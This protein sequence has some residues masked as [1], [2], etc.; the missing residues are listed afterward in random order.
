MKRTKS[1]SI[2]KNILLNSSKSIT[3]LEIF[4]IAKKDGVT[5]STIH[6]TRGP[7]EEENLIK[8]DV[9][10]FTSK[11]SYSW[12]EEEHGH[13]L[14]C[15]KCHKQIILDYCPFEEVNKEVEKKTGFT[16]EDENHVLYGLCSTCKEKNE[17]QK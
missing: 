6:R 7:F 1:R 8:K 4:E 13:I 9:S 2:I 17:K 3:A 14:E 16:L 11:A 15:I 10:P 5:L 12:K